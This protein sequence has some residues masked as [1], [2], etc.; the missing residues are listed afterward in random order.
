[1]AETAQE[2]FGNYLTQHI[3]SVFSMVV[4]IAEEGFQRDT[5]PFLQSKDRNA[6]IARRLGQ[7]FLGAP[8]AVA[9][10]HGHET[11]TRKNERLLLTAL[12]GTGQLEPWLDILKAQGARL[13]GIYSLPLLT[14]GLMRQLG[15]KIHIGVLVTLQDNSIRQ[16]FFNEGRLVFSRV[17]PVVGNSISDVAA[18]V[19][20]EANR[21]EQYLLSQRMMSNAYRLSAHVL[22]HPR[23]IES[24]QAA[25]FNN[26]MEVTIHDITAAAKKI[27]FKSPLPDTRAQGLFLQIAA[28]SP[29]RQ[30]FATAALRQPYRVWQ[31]GSMIRVG[32]AIALAAC[33]VFATKL[34]VEARQINDNTQRI[35]QEASVMEQNYQQ[36]LG[37]LPPIPLSNDAL[38]QLVDRIESLR[39]INESPTPAFVHLSQ[40]LDAT[41]QIE[42]SELDWSATGARQG[43]AAPTGSPGKDN[44][45]AALETLK[46]KGSVLMGS[47]TSTRT[48]IST[49]EAF[50]QRLRDSHPKASVEVLQT[51]VDLNASRAIKSTEGTAKSIAPRSFTV[52]I[53]Y[54]VQP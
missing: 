51:P 52:Q 47:E 10:P 3:N 23:N 36:A 48:L 8:L 53:Q 15:I 26:D 50:T 20:S 4:N 41:P 32:G 19:A 34:M 44:K 28:T 38:R 30:Q 42:I 18:C 12:T 11:G 14:E 37:R 25:R 2:S 39:R 7:S 1:M 31:W 43:E 33:A 46:V 5:I 24:I 16:S 17:A 21:F 9:I 6:V 35:A 22:A 13:K 45:G 29:P 49:F 40:A 54:P 27:G